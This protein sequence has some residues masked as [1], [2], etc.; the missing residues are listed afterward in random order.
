MV[1]WIKQK[2]G[3]LRARIKWPSWGGGGGIA[4][5]ILLW[6]V[7]ALAVF[8]VALGIYWS[9]EPDPFSVRLN[10]AEKLAI[11]GQDM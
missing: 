6:G 2:W 5:R 9:W 1:G 8:V 11:T 3:N 4:R 7:G 10:T